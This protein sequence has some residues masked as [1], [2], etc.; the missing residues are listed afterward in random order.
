[1]HRYLMRKYI[2][3][4]IFMISLFAISIC[5]VVT[6]FDSIVNDFKKAS[7]PDELADS[8][9]ASIEDNI[10]YKE[11]L[12]E[13][14]G[15]THILLDKKENNGFDIV[16][17]KD[18]I[19]YYSQRPYADSTE[20]MAE[21][22]SRIEAAV[23]DTDTQVLAFIMPDKYV[24]EKGNYYPGIPYRNGNAYVDE[25]IQSLEKRNI[26]YVDFRNTIINS[27]LPLDELFYKTDHHWNEQA[28]FLAYKD[29][30]SFF[31]ETYGLDLDP[32][33]IYTN[34]NSYNFKTYEDIMLGSM[35]RKTGIIYGG[36]EDF[37]VMYP[38]HET[39]I[40]VVYQSMEDSEEYEYTGSF[41]NTLLNLKFLQEE[42]VYVRDCYTAFAGGI[43]H[44]ISIVNEDNT[45]GPKVLML[46]DS[47]SSPFNLFFIQSC[48]EI[49]GYWI[50]EL[51][52]DIEDIMVE[53][54]YDYIIV[55]TYVESLGLANF[56]FFE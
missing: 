24:E 13:L 5:Y 10:M 12:V 45:E 26:T 32:E 44:K 33:G 53:G 22:V 35:G 48:S 3:T 55:S 31:K 21:R 43:N 56:S 11:E 41:E 52:E 15:F 30:V 50:T 51:P 14:F 49:E 6:D 28:A 36:M 46:M 42:D 9:D 29:A 27:D 25:Y 38:K 54:E 2:F 8:I 7:D 40:K 17:D 1:M 20:V 19:M 47:F 16:V 34:E 37:S 23:K 39:N 18:G 4:V